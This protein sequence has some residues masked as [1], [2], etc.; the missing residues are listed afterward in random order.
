MNIKQ[1]DE[2]LFRLDETVKNIWRLTEKQETHLSKLNESILNHAIQISSHRTSIRWIK[3]ILISSGV[4]GGSA[5]GLFK[6]LG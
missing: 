3:Y 5:F 2:L 6:W 4:L 1:R